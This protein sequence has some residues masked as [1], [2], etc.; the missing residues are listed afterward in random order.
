MLLNGKV[1][2]QGGSRVTARELYDP[3]RCTWTAT[4]SGSDLGP[5][6]SR[7][8]LLLTDG[9]WSQEE[10]ATIWHDRRGSVEL[11]DPR[12]GRL[13]KHDSGAVGAD[14]VTLPRDGWALVT[15]AAM[16]S[17]AEIYETDSGP[18]VPSISLLYH[19]DQILSFD[20]SGAGALEQ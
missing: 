8:T 9:C 19:A 16:R 3:D 6:E 20:L 1:L 11:Y 5:L 12:T 15:A 13:R 7:A 18:A 2:V 17:S 14:T 10:S 4:G